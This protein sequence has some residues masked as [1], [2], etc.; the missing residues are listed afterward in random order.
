MPGDVFDQDRLSLSLSA[1]YTL[2]EAWLLTLGYIFRDGD[3]ASTAVPNNRIIAAAEA[4]TD[5]P[6]FG[7]G[8]FAYRLDAEVHTLTVD[9][10]RAMGRD[11]SL[12]IGYQF[13]QTNAAGGIDYDK[14]LLQLSYVHGF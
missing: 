5:D 10:D 2:S 3:V 14:S 4:I 6:A 9:L 13:Q 11:S 8:R 7:V 1:D 12:V